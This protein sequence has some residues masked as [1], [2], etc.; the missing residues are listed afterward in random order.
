MIQILIHSSKTMRVP[1]A[2]KEPL[3]TPFF[4]SQAKHLVSTYRALDTKAI[5]KIMAVSP[6]KAAEVKQLLEGWSP[7]GAQVPAIDAFVGD[8]YSGLQVQTWDEADRRYAH[9]H[10]LIL[11]GLYGALRACDGILPYRL[12]MGYKL[13]TG[14]NLYS[15]WK[16]ILAT[17]IAK[18]TNVIINLS[19]VEYTRALLPYALQPVITPKFLTVS[20]KTDEPTFVTVHTK[21]ARGAYAKWLIVNR[22]RSLESLHEFNEL[23]YVYDESLS[24]KNQPVYVAQQFEGI[25]L[26]VRL[27]K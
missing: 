23:G 7:S 26:S 20:P 3:G 19:A 10:L 17:C 15:F 8:I 4:V 24:T 1:A 6:K 9:E 22:I 21:I 25:G 27:T 11:S 12:E 13:P 14:E 5:A 2:V 18:D 16:D